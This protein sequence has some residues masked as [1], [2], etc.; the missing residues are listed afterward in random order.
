MIQPRFTTPAY[1]RFV[2]LV[3]K[4]APDLILC[5]S[6]SM[7]LRTDILN[8]PREGVVNVHGGI[9]PQYRGGNPV[10]W[11]IINDE[12][13]AGVT[14]HYMDEGF[15]SGPV[16]AQRRVPLLFTDTWRDV[17][18]RLEVATEDLLGEQIALILVGR[19]TAVAQDSAQSRHYPHRKPADGRIDWSQP[20][21]A[22]YNLV[23]ALVAPLPGAFY[24]TGDA[25]KTLSAYLTIA[26]VAALKQEILGGRWPALGPN[27]LRVNA[28]SSQAHIWLDLY[29]L[30][31]GQLG[32]AEIYSIDYAA[33]TADIR[34]SSVE[35]SG[36]RRAQALES[37]RD[38]ARTELGLSKVE[39]RVT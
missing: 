32:G 39:T 30:Q 21:R 14:M 16:I 5:D 3:T 4:L 8:V 27:A 2:R 22:I 35:P 20:I 29:D 26:E 11:A 7:L 19:A 38:F 6:Y 34:L 23:R 25:T 28:R 1:S 17:M 15:D 13:Q 12:M 9:L 33:R 37:A 31:G 24:V 18:K 10:Q 36:P